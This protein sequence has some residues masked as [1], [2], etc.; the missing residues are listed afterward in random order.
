MIIYTLYSSCKS[1]NIEGIIQAMKKV[2]LTL[3][4][5]LLLIT[6]T[7]GVVLYGKGYRISF[8]SGGPD[9][10]GTGLLVATSSPDG[11]Q[12]F[13]N[14]HLTT[15]TDNTINLA[16]G[17]YK[18]RI[19]KDG[20]FPWEK[21]LV[22]NK[23]IVTKA[24]ALLFPT[25][26]KLESITNLGVEDPVMDPTKTKL[27]YTVSSQTI[28]KNGVYIL[29][30]TTRPILTLQG[31][32]SQIADDTT[33]LFS[34]ARL[35]WAPDGS[36]M[37]ASISAQGSVSSFLLRPSTFNDTPSDITATLA[38]TQASWSKIQADKD[39]ATIASLPVKVR[40]LVR[41][42][43]RVI[44]FAP[45]D[46]K[47]LYHASKSATLPIIISPRLIGTDS[48]P[49]ERDIVKDSVYVYDVKEDRNYLIKDRLDTSKEALS[50]LPDSEHLLHVVDKIINIMEFDGA[51]NTKIYAG[52]FLDHYVFP[53]PDMSKIVILTN[54]GNTATPPNLYTISLK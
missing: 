6:A 28:K 9:V 51:N 19:F 50:W 52:P 31:S 39:R 33:G 35:S 4:I 32:S 45:D 27:A 47:I 5:L 2:V 24:D 21:T 53:W 29:D 14:D 10:S 23:G 37:I 48:T 42:N 13:V 44:A 26:P 18:V 25:A 3:I 36:E 12:V 1:Y 22:V 43:F 38:T 20:Y 40:N 34:S 49:E 8:G 17:T 30:M 46:T 11:A 41:E 54:L 7:V 16:P 15:A